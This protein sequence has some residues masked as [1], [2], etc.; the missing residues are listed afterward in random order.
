MHDSIGGGGG[1][2]CQHTLRIRGGSRSMHM[3]K[4]KTKAGADEKRAVT[5]VGAMVIRAL[6]YM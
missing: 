6:S 4:R 5:S 1:G 3:E 2:D